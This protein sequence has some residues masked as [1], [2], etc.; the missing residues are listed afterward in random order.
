[1]S[2]PNETNVSDLFW[3][4]AASEPLPQ[5]QPAAKSSCC[6]PKPAATESS[7][8]VQVAAAPKASSCCGPKPATEATEAKAKSSCCG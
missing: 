5:A 2:M 3:S 6:G 8:A 4:A 7:E 1:M